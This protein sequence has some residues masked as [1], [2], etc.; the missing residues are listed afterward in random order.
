MAAGLGGA[1]L[2]AAAGLGG[3]GGGTGLD[4]H[5]ARMR[6][7]HGAQMQQDAVRGQDG[8]KGLAGQR[9]RDVWRSNLHQEM[10]LLRSL[11]DQYPYISMVSTLSP[12]R[13]SIQFLLL[14]SMCL[15][16]ALE[17]Y[18]Q[19][20]MRLVLSF[21]LRYFDAH[22]AHTWTRTQSFP[23]LLHGLLVTLTRK[24]PTTTK[25]YAAMSTSSR[26][27]SSALR[28]SRYKAKSLP[29]SSTRLH[30][31]T[32]PSRCSGTRTTSS[33]ARAHGALTSSSRSR[34]TCTTKSLSRC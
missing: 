6:F 20:A 12:S 28:C 5:E 32:S 4:G 27:S 17:V 33:C 21:V 30:C 8:A 24:P 22:Y 18:C 11:I 2:G 26:S 1:G 31:S 14:S 25:Q 10:D 29:H 13:G 15:T 19:R 34:T 23:V 7:A 3:V 16:C 9:I